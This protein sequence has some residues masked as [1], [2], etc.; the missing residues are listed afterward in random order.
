MTHPGIEQT[1]HTVREAVCDGR[2][3]YEAIRALCTRYPAAAAT[4]IMDLTVEAEAF[5]ARILFPENEVPSV[6]G[7][8]LTDAAEIAALRVPTLDAG[9]VGEYLGAARRAAGGSPTAPSS[10][11]ASAPSRWPAASTGSRSS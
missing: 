2:V 3:H 9:R 8:L 1:G 7:R 10:A 4:M 5:G 11:A 6:T